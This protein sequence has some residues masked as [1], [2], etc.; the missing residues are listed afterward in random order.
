MLILLTPEQSSSAE[1]EQLIQLF[2]DGLPLLHVRKPG[3]SRE[4]LTNWLSQ[5]KECHLNR[6]VLHQHHDLTEVFALRG[7][8]LKESFRRKQQDCSDLIKRK[9]SK[10]F[11]ISSSFHDLATLEKEGPL[12]NYSFLSPVFSSISKSA[13]KGQSLHVSALPQQVIALGGI[14]A[15]R[16]QQAK[17]MGYAGVA[18]L[19][20]IWLAEDKRK[21]FE[22]IHKAYRNVYD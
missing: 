19:G 4:K 14:K 21:A 17:K 13:Y 22:E 9:Q 6:M 16:I 3:M 8:H 7:I 20:A 5:F 18:V 15:D 11:T 2:R 12:F 10:G 1:K